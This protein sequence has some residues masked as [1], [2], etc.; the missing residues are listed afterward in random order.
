[1]IEA[2]LAAPGTGERPVAAVW[3]AVVSVIMILHSR[4]STV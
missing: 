2:T 3:A 4:K 1:M